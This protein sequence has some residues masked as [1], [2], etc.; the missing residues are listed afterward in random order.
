MKI[1]QKPKPTFTF[2]NSVRSEAPRTISGVAIGRK[3]RMLVAPRPWKRCR[4]IASAMSVPSAVA[5]TV[6]RT[7]SSSDVI[8]ADRIPG[9]A[10]QW[11]Q[12][13]RVKPSQ[14]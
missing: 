12:L 14:R 10:S 8:T 11:I 3:M 13:S 4:T 7:A 6:E 1:V 9:T 2:T 5:I